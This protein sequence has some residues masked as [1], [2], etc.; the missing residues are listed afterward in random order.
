M[1]ISIQYK[2][3]TYCI[4]TYF[5]IMAEAT[6]NG[7]GIPTNGIAPIYAN[8]TN[9][10]DVGDLEL[11]SDDEEEEEVL[12]GELS[13]I[14]NDNTGYSSSSYGHTTREDDSSIGS[15]GSM[16]SVSSM[17]TDLL[18]FASPIASPNVS[19]N[20]IGVGGRRVRSRSRSKSKTRRKSRAKR[21]NKTTRRRRRTKKNLNPGTMNRP[22]GKLGGKRKT[23]KSKP[24]KSKRKTRRK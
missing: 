22:Y 15:I 11:D 7:L 23:K 1:Y 18:A 6:I 3:C 10:L 8:Q 9:Y 14:G 16:S 12:Q 19:I 2:I 4:V 13:S 17:D 5:S 20:S 24:D 21:G